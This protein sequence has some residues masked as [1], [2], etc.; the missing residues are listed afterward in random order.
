MLAQKTFAACQGHRNNP[1]Q[2]AAA[3]AI[4]SSKL[5]YGGTGEARTHDSKIKSL[6][7]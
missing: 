4:P 7:L 1:A 3:K 6:V 2:L 5:I